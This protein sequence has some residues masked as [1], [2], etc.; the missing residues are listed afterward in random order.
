MPRQATNPL[1][2]PENQK[3]LVTSYVKYYIEHNPKDFKI[4]QQAIKYIRSTNANKFGEMEGTDLR[5]TLELPTMLFT[6]VNAVLPAWFNDLKN[7]DWFEK[8][9]PIFTTQDDMRSGVTGS[10]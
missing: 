3:K 8:K 1:A 7:L 10:K 9:F 5:Q 6:A 4:N 2:D